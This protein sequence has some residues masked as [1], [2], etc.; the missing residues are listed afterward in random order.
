MTPIKNYNLYHLYQNWTL[1]LIILQLNIYHLT[2]FPVKIVSVYWCCN[3]IV[4]KWKSSFREMK[5]FKQNPGSEAELGLK[6]S[7]T[8]IHTPPVSRRPA[9]LVAV[10]RGSLFLHWSRG[11]RRHRRRL[12]AILQTVTKCLCLTAALTHRAEDQKHVW[13]HFVSH[14]CFSYFL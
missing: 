1:F 2:I 9:R 6:A 10:C 14:F 5:L 12:L 7:V 4:G 11:F 3:L 8:H 13:L